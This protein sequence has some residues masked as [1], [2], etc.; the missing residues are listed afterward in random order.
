MIKLKY[1]VLIVTELQMIITIFKSCNKL[2]PKPLK[3]SSIFIKH[4][5][6][7]LHQFFTK[8]SDSFWFVLHELQS[9]SVLPSNCQKLQDSWLLQVSMTMAFWDFFQ[10]EQSWAEARAPFNFLIINLNLFC[11]ITPWSFQIH[12]CHQSKVSFRFSLLLKL[13]YAFERS[14]NVEH[15]ASCSLWFGSLWRKIYRFEVL[16]SNLKM[17]DPVAV[18]GIRR[19]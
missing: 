17:L 16:C 12:C 8:L 2:S 3:N 18:L 4:F 6:T 13:S 5:S 14:S 10:S 1:K 11:I 15:D 9:P 19:K 7:F